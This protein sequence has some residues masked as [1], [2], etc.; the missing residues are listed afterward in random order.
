M[1]TETGASIDTLDAI[2]GAI[3]YFF[4]GVIVLVI[5]LKS[6]SE[7]VLSVKSWFF[8]RSQ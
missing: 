7:L 4:I 8:K 5:V 3:G 2:A 1:E 6:V